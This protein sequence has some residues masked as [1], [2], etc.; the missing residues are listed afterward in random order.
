MDIVKIC[1]KHGELTIEQTHIGISRGYKYFRCKE[2][3]KIN[4]KNTKLRTIDKRKEYYKK[5][6][7]Q[8]LKRFKKH[9]DQNKEKRKKQFK[10]WS[11]RN[12]TRGLKSEHGIIFSH[13]DYLKLS[14][15]QNHVCAICKKPE[16][17]LSRKRDRI[18]GLS[19]DHCHETNKIRGLLCHH[20]NV[21]L[22]SFNDSIEL[23][24]SAINYLKS[25][26]Q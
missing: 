18:K 12:K 20:C 10:N 16:K 19:I 17:I 23:L 9:Y 22:G 25:T 14:E 11:D 15:N 5:N 2:C 24:Q 7:E 26:N 1:K 6:K 3:R 8:I 13:E 21:A 4:D